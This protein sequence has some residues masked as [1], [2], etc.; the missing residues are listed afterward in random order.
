MATYETT[1]PDGTVYEF[2]G[3]DNATDKQLNDYVQR[4]FG[5]EQTI[6]SRGTSGA[7][8][9]SGYDYK[10]EETS[11]VRDVADVATGLISGT[12]KAAGALVGLGSLVPGL[13]YVADPLSAWLQKGGEALDEALLSDRQKRLTK[14]YPHDFKKLQVH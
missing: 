6:P 1:G 4:T 14:N 13:H 11:G 10:S 9:D 8:T 7:Q 5:A 2:D 3:P 12:A